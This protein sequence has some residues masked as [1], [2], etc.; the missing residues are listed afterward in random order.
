MLSRVLESSRHEPGPW[1]LGLQPKLRE[2]PESLGPIYQ[3]KQNSKETTEADGLQALGQQVQLNY[4]RGVV[5]AA[6]VQ[7]TL[8]AVTKI[9]ARPWERPSLSLS[10]FPLGKAE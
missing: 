7:E 5:E 10:S 6:E 3:H 1:C 9:A 2:V 8:G 4:F